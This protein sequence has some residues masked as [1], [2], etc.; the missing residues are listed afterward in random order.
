MSRYDIEDFCSELDTYMKENLATYLIAIDSEKHDGFEIEKI[1]SEAYIQ[2]DIIEAPQTAK[3]HNPFLIHG[4]VETDKNTS[5]PAVAK[6]YKYDVTIVFS[7]QGDNNN[8]KRMW[9]YQRALSDMI[10]V[11]WDQMNK[12]V[13][14]EVEDLTP[15]P[16]SL[17][18]APS[19]DMWAVGIRL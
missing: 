13:R 2:Q 19:M 7:K 12:R 8:I 9:R 3:S 16:I 10:E 14:L 11:G 4:V 6:V 1:N 5:G 18:N 17:L 15:I